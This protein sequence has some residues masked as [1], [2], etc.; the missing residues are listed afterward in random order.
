MTKVISLSDSA[1]EGLK[2]LKKGN[3]SFSEVVNRITTYT[4]RNSL[5]DLAGKWTGGKEELN[6]IEKMIYEDRKKFKLRKVE[7]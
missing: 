1:Y 5:L 6:K 4:K 3:E 2:S 7:F